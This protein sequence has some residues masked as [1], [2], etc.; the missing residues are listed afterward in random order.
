MLR[1]RQDVGRRR[2][3]ENEYRDSCFHAAGEVNQTR[4]DMAFNLTCFR[5]NCQKIKNQ[6]NTTQ[7]FFKII[8]YYKPI[9]DSQQR[10]VHNNSNSMRELADLTRNFYWF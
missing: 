6:G 3:I 1:F 2:N 4:I 8:L 5:A 7:H 10:K 9:P